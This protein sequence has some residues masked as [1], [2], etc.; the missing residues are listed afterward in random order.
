MIELASLTKGSSIPEEKLVE[1]SGLR[2]GTDAFRLFCLNLISQIEKNIYFDRG[3]RVVVVH[4]KGAIR[5][6]TDSEAT[7]DRENAFNNAIKSAYRRHRQLSQVDRGNLN[8]TERQLHDRR[9]RNTGLQTSLLRKA[10]RKPNLV[11]VTRNRPSR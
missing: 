7:I 5:V 11:P 9:L 8:A 4:R 2:K 10:R 3:E 6:L 1:W